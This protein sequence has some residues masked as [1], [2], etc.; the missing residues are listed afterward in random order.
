[1]ASVT[2]GFT[3]TV[4]RTKFPSINTVAQKLTIFGCVTR[5]VTSVSAA[6]RMFVIGRSRWNYKCP[7]ATNLRVSLGNWPVLSTSSVRSP[8]KSLHYERKQKTWKWYVWKLLGQPVF[9]SK[10][11]ASLV[12][13]LRISFQ[14]LNTNFLVYWTIYESFFEEWQWAMMR[15]HQMTSDEIGWHETGQ[16]F[17]GRFSTNNRNNG[18]TNRSQG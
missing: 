18:P 14:L 7:A 16:I 12:K 3:E 2:S 11:T 8:I 4:P 6:G 17:R 9:S 1:M 10:N 5:S 13:I 15:K